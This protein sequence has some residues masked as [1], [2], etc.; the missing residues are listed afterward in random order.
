MKVFK[1]IALI[2]PAILLVIVVWGRIEPFRLDVEEQQAPIPN[3]P[4]A[5]EGQ[6]VAQIS[7]WQLG[8][9]LGNPSTVEQ[10]VARI[11]EEQPALVLL[12]G[13][14][15]YHPVDDTEEEIRRAAALASP[16]WRRACRPTRCW[17]TTTM[18]WPATARR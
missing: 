12:T 5:W 4:A 17:A 9:W 2:L 11:V 3:L 8:M 18:P 15:V 13:D 10:A 1:R 6:R 16:S 7:D 14:F